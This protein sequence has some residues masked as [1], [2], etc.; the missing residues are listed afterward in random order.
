MSNLNKQQRSAQKKR[1]ADKTSNFGAEIETYWL[2]SWVPDPGRP[3]YSK[4]LDSLSAAKDYA[5]MKKR[6]GAI[7]IQIHEVTQMTKRVM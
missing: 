1:M 7:D 6:D 2:V 4:R 3:V 5:V